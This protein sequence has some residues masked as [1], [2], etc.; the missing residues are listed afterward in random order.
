MA[1]IDDYRGQAD[2]CRRLAETE[3]DPADRSV[4]LLLQS[5]WMRLS[6]D[7]PK[8]LAAPPSA[9]TPAPSTARGKRR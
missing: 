1:L 5:A 9:A 8:M 6:D 4:W 7:A 2:E 3:S